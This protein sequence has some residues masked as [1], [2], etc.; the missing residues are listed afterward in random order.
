[1]IPDHLEQE[2]IENSDYVRAL[3]RV[4]E[5]AKVLVYGDLCRAHEQRPCLSCLVGA[6]DRDE[7]RTAL[8]EAELLR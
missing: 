2:I 5:A 7:L 6:T 1:M 8:E 4:Q 3:E